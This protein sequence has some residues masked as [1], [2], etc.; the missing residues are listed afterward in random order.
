MVPFFLTQLIHVPCQEN[1]LS[2]SM[3]D[4]FILLNF[5]ALASRESNF[6]HVVVTLNDLSH[7]FYP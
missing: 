2:V 3:S 6:M 7:Y 1:N 4:S 5:A